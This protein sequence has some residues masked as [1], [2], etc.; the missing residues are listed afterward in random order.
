MASLTSRTMTVRATEPDRTR[1]LFFPRRSRLL[2]PPRDA[3]D[4]E[5]RGDGTNQRWMSAEPRRRGFA[6][7]MGRFVASRGGCERARDGGGRRRR[8]V[9][10]VSS[11]RVVVVVVVRRGGG[12]G[13]RRTMSVSI[14]VGGGERGVGCGERRA[15]KRTTTREECVRGGCEEEETKARRRRDEDGWAR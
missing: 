13:R 11:N 5:P 14:A 10:F 4:A 2:D 12:E 9:N 1:A 3:L 8:A 15:K 7:A 6:R